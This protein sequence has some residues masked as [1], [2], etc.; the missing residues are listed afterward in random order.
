[1]NS[2]PSNT[3]ILHN[4]TAVL[5]L[6]TD[7]RRLASRLLFLSCYK[8]NGIPLRTTIYLLSSLSSALEMSIKFFFLRSTFI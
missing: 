1:M 8:F 7:R 4:F 3:C 2:I 6:L 5:S